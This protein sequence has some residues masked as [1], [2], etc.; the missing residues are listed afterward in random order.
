MVSYCNEQ[1]GKRTKHHDVCMSQDIERVQPGKSVGGMGAL[2]DG[3]GALSR[4]RYLAANR[5]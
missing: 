4:A 3:D 1:G 5:A 2:W